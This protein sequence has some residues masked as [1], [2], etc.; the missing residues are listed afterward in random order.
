[1]VGEFFVDIVIPLVLFCTAMHIL[2]EEVD[3]LKERINKLEEI[4]Q[5]RE[6]IK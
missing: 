3:E 2:N 5:K 6:V 1:M 4:L